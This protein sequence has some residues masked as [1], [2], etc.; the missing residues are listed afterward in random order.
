MQVTA[1]LFHD[2]CASNLWYRLEEHTADFSKQKK[3]SD[4]LQSDLA[5]QEE[6]IEAFK[7]VTFYNVQIMMHGNFLNAR[8]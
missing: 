1:Y 3:L 8:F 4:K 7:K 6:Q 2:E 5:M